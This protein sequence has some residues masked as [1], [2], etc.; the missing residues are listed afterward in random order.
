[1]DAPNR[2]QKVVIVWDCLTPPDD[3]PHRPDDDD[4]FYPDPTDGTREWYEEQKA[5]ADARMRAWENE[6][7]WFVGVIARARV[8]VPIGGHSFFNLTIDSPG[9]WQIESDSPEY[10]KEV[11]GDE[12]ARLREYLATVGWAILTSDAVESE[13][14]A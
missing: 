9:L 5:L 12:K 13:K 6:E 1:M 2:P 14:A 10:V 11:Y 3:Q 4:G 7:W 8:S